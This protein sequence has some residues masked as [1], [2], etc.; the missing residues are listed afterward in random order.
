MKRILSKLNRV[1]H[2]MLLRNETSKSD[3]KDYSAIL[4]R[5]TVVPC[6][7]EA[8]FL[9]LN[10]YLEDG[11]IVLDVGFGLGYGLNI[12]AIKASEVS[13]VDIDPQALNYCQGTVV[14]RNPR[15][16]DL[17]L[18]DGYNIEY[19]DGYFYTVT[20]VDVLEHV[21]DYDQLLQE[22]LRVTRKG[23]LISTPN[24]RPEYTNSDGSPKNY[25]HL[26]EWSYDELNTI[27]AKHGKVEWNFLDGP[28]EGP[29][30]T[31]KVQS[32]STITLT[33]F[34]FR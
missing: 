33:P 15:L 8:Y 13:G 20:C 17:A 26:R 18:Y 27:L 21:E 11:D 16:K 7:I 12:L 1:G 2:R 3:P 25:F 28:Y 30:I 9:A 19:Q 31:R 34:L 14:G 24:R 10:R 22:M 4:G 29:F 6:Q 5:G 23:V 32:K